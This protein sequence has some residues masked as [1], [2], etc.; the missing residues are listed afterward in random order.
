MTQEEQ[1]LANQMT[2]LSE[3]GEIKGIVKGH[4]ERIDKLE[5]NEKSFVSYRSA[6]LFVVALTGVGGIVTLVTKL[7]GAW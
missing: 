3:L 4:G 7:A 6:G 1:L 2:M 5:K